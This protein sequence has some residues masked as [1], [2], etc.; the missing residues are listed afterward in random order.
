MASYTVTKSKPAT[1][2]GGTVDTITFAR[3]Y[4]AV[5]VVNVDGADEIYFTVDGVGGPRKDGVPTVGGEDTELV[6]ASV[7]AALMVLSSSSAGGTVVRLI[8]ATAT[9]YFVRGVEG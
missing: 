9:E 1:T 5:E 6:P 3:D 4:P 8:S 2:V 7:G